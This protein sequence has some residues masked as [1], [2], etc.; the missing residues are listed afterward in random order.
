MSPDKDTC[1]APRFSV[2]IPVYNRKCFIQSTIAS[3]FCQSYRPLEIIV[4]DDGSSD[5][6]AAV[7]R[8]LTGPVPVVYHHQPNQG[9]SAARNVGV[10]LARGEWVAFLDSDDLWYPH[11]LAVIVESLKA[12]PG[13]AVMYSGADI[14]EEEEKPGPVIGAAPGICRLLFGTGPFPRPSTLVVHRDAFLRSKGFDPQI[15]YCEDLE[16]FVRLANTCQVHV[17]HESLIKYR[18]HDQQT[19]R[20][21]ESHVESYDRLYNALMALWS[22]DAGKRAVLVQDAGGFFYGVGRHYLRTGDF[23]LARHFYRRASDYYPLDGRHLWHLILSY[24]PGLREFYGYW[25]RHNWYRRKKRK[26]DRA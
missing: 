25:Y 23:K 21:L 11:K 5:G 24:L 20:W 15:H 19:S 18:K 14:I 1:S 12:R 7:V 10:S 13:V 26:R 8:E 9:P 16:L 22:G 4:V 3:V 2:V 6:T 17:I